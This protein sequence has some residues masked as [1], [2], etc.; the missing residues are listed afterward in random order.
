M[1]A[2]KWQN[3]SNTACGM[4]IYSSAPNKCLLVAKIRG[5]KLQR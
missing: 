3:E 4:S 2:L 1:T 5:F